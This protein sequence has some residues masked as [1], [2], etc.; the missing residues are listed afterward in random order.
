MKIG[1][2][3]FILPLIF[4]FFAIV[5]CEKDDGLTGSKENF[6]YE[7]TALNDPWDGKPPTSD[8]ELKAFVSEYLKS[9]LGIEFSHLSITHDGTAEG[10]FAP[11]CR[12]GRIIRIEADKAYQDVLIENGFKIK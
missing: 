5:A 12:T 3:K 1:N 8:A 11:H 7:E 2:I 6:Y 9:T 10:C 4:I